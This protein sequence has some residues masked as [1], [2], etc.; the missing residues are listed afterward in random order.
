MELLRMNILL[1]WHLTELYNN[2][3]ETLRDDRL[4]T[5][6]LHANNCF[7]SSTLS[8]LIGLGFARD[9]LLVFSRIHR[10]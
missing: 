8:Q 5:S 1:I 4:D 10:Q 9:G 3:C 6:L 2:R 7:F